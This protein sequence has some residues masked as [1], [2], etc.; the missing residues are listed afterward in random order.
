MGQRRRHARHASTS[1][2]AH[3]AEAAARATPGG[4]FKWHVLFWGNQQPTWIYD[5]PPDQQLD[6]INK[7]LAAIAADF[8]NIDQIDVVN[9]ALHDPPDKTSA[10]N[11][12]A[13]WFGRIHRCARRRRRH[14][15]G[16]DHQR[17]SRWRDSTSRIPS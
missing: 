8:P 13:R 1:T 15:L 3:Q 17:A 12:T 10:G 16:L 5:L 14:G 2:Q 4:V 9:E 11:T 6:E 7:W